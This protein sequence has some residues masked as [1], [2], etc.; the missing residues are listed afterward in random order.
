MIGLVFLSE[1]KNLRF[2]QRYFAS[3]N[4]TRRVMQNRI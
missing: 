3:L 1:A 4:M 2:F